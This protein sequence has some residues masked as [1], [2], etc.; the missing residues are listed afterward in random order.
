MGLRVKFWPTF[1]G[2]LFLYFKLEVDGRLLTR[3]LIFSV[4]ITL[5]ATNYRNFVDFRL[6]E[7]CHL[8]KA[9][10]K[11]PKPKCDLNPTDFLG[12]I[13]TAKR[14]ASTEAFWTSPS[15]FLELFFKPIIKGK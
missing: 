14:V 10:E 6:R 9:T 2:H 13:C 12:Q 1:V 3:I 15:D 4:K 7:V 8:S 11:S 5:F